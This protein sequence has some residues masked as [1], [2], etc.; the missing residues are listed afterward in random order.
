MMHINHKATAVEAQ[1]KEDEF[2][3]CDNTQLLWGLPLWLQQ[4]HAL[5]A[6]RGL[7]ARRDVRAWASQII[8]LAPEFAE[9]EKAKAHR[10]LKSVG[11]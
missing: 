4:F 11:F 2:E 10:V 9:P 7:A 1:N 8:L 5:L 6:K 3:E